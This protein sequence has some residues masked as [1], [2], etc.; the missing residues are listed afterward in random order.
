MK[1]FEISDELESLIGREVSEEGEIS[2]EGLAAL[3]AIEGDFKAKL[4]D[5][6]LWMLGEE[7]EIPALARAIATL[8]ARKKSKQK[9]VEWMKKYMKENM[10]RSGVD[11]V[12]DPRVK[13]SWRTSHAVE[14]DEDAPLPIELLRMPTPTPNLDAIGKL[15]D[16][17]KEVEGARRITRR[18]LQVK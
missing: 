16:S 2:E 8:Q 17:G 3:D 9:S 5:C 10:E 18:N 12:S 14:V 1:L 6:G 13:I 4:V 11:E 7:A 15:L